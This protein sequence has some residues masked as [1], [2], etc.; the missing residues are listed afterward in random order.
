VLLFSRLERVTKLIGGASYRARAV[1]ERLEDGRIM[2]RSSG[3]EH[4]KG[5]VL[6]AAR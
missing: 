3:L 1:V 2:L 5:S 6:N 4:R